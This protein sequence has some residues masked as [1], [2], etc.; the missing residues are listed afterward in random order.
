MFMSIVVFDNFILKK[1]LF[2]IYYSYLFIMKI[3]NFYFFFRPIN[4]YTIS[5]Q[6]LTSTELSISL[7]KPT[8]KG[9]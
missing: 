4:A 2:I 7:S 9:W 1:K 6:V 5:G 3:E 8:R